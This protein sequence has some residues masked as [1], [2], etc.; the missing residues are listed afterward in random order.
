MT[1]DGRRGLF[2]T[3]EGIEGSGK[4]SQIGRLARKLDAAGVRVVSTREPGGTSL[5]ARLRSVLLD[6]AREGI[7]PRAE[8]LLYVADR[9]QHL[10]EIVEPALRRREVVLCDRYLDATVAY[11]GFGR[12]LGAEA[13]LALHR[14]PPLDRRPDR[15]ILF[16]LDP[17][18]GLARARD[19][20]RR[21]GTERSEGRF[22]EEDLA[23]HR[24]V[25]EGYLS[26]AA[27]DPR[28]IRVVD[29]AGTE[30]SVEERVSSALVDLL[31]HL[32]GGRP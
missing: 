14:E 5:G 23:F 29:G 15:T 19:R 30:D 20:N 4:S 12:G 3:F 6:A 13:V 24:R 2:L 21:M 22:E 7:S 26:L 8:L 25:R 17:G 16:D 28:R 27:E 18:A 1:A 11:Q 31:P 10:E 9:A 32:T